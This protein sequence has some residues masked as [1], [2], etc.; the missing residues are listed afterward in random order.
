MKIT[1]LA[2]S[3]SGPPY[4]VEFM[5]QD[6]SV[7]VFCH[8]QAGV[9]QQMCKHKLGLIKGDLTM[10]FDAQQAPLLSEVHAWPQFSSLK[11]RTDEF[12]KKLKETE[13]AR[14]ALA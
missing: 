1:I 6:L 10:L 4:T 9:M 14:E 2:K 13:A 11:T 12:E 8:C 3:S 5:Q 7:R